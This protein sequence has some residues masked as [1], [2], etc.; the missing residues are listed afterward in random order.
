ML[1]QPKF[2]VF[3]QVGRGWREE[4][5]GMG[6]GMEREGSLSGVFNC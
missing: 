6:Q 5:G 1:P 2:L 4:W 3:S